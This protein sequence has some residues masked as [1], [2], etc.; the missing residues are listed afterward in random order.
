MVY[1]S[2]GF[3]QF[4]ENAI[5]VG[6][7]VAD[8]LTTI[9]FG[10][11]P[12]I[13]FS[14][15]YAMM[16]ENLGTAFHIK[17]S[18]GEKKATWMA[19][20]D[21][22]SLELQNRK[23]AE[24]FDGLGESVNLIQ[25]DLKRESAS[26]SKYLSQLFSTEGISAKFEKDV[27]G[28]I[29]DQAIAQMMLDT[30]TEGDWRDPNVVTNVKKLESTIGPSNKTFDMWANTEA[31]R[32]ELEYHLH[33]MARLIGPKGPAFVKNISFGETT[34]MVTKK[35]FQTQMKGMD[36]SADQIAKSWKTAVDRSM[37]NLKKKWNLIGTDLTNVVNSAGKELGKGSGHESGPEDVDYFARQIVNRMQEIQNNE[38]TAGE[39]VGYF[40]HAPTS[41]DTAGYVT[42]RPFFKPSPGG[43]APTLVKI[44]HDT[45]VIQLTHPDLRGVDGV[46]IDEDILRKFGSLSYF[47]S[48]YS[49]IL[50][51]ALQMG[52]LDKASAIAASNQIK[53][54]AANDLALS[55]GRGEMLGSTLE[56]EVNV[57]MGNTVGGMGVVTATE[58]LS[59]MEAANSLQK[60]FKAFFGAKEVSKWLEA[61]YQHASRKSN[62]ITRLWASKLK[63]GDSWKIGGGEKGV[64]GRPYEDTKGRKLRGV[65]VP[66]WYSQGR[67]PAAFLLF[68]Q[69]ETKSPLKKYFG[70][71]GTHKQYTDPQ[72]AYITQFHG[73]ARKREGSFYRR[74][75]VNEGKFW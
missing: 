45:A 66:W 3:Q 28:E 68:K 53:Q 20:T 25:G 32:Q 15:N 52:F 22:L 44:E 17:P 55:T 63:L 13:P 59:S 2:L 29:E 31:Q 64:F 74:G 47:S 30:L 16:H 40:F 1:Q 43:G 35:Y 39:D 46:K 34:N 37:A 19:K 4:T 73:G 12:W 7:V 8:N 14:E 48:H 5:K 50:Q 27:K 11:S 61:F 51:D 36:K 67:N 10:M 62:D 49:M 6:S 60:Q 9:E 23:N 21:A 26:I 42:I 57:A 75:E 24:N 72:A 33:A 65:G 69:T 18:E 70:P 58:T 41:K 54:F 38:A 56:T 71:E